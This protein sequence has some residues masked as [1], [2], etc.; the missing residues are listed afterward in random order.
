MQNARPDPCERFHK[1]TYVAAGTSYTRNLS[2]TYEYDERDRVKKV[3][4]NGQ[5]TGLSGSNV[6]GE[7][8]YTYDENS[9][10]T[11]ESDWNGVASTHAYCRAPL[12]CSTFYQA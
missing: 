4:R 3:T 2:L 5:T 11:S 7:K 10:L 1:D 12:S 6:A 9:N 8:T